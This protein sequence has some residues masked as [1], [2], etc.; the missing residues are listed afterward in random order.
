MKALLAL[1]LLL[2]SNLSLAQASIEQGSC[3][4]NNHSLY[5]DLDTN[6]SMGADPLA[7]LKSGLTLYL[8]YDIIIKEQGSWFGDSIELQRA[9]RLR[10][11]PVAQTFVVEEPITLNQQNHHSLEEALDAIGRINSL[12]LIE[13][14]ALPPNLEPNNLQIK[15][16]FQLNQALLPVSLRFTALTAK[17][18]R[19]KSDWWTCQPNT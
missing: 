10:Y 5:L 9:L 11:N 18:W 3:Y 14:S 12:P 2:S 8:H 19:L 13:L 17:E 6:I 16:R 4:L 7:A 1:L 15:V